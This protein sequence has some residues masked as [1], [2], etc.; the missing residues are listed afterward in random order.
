MQPEKQAPQ[1]FQWDPAPAPTSE[2]VAPLLYGAT[3]Q[4]PQGSVQPMMGM[5]TDMRGEQSTQA[6]MALVLSL[7]SIVGGILFFPAFLLAPVSLSLANKSLNVTKMYPGHSEHGMA[8]AAQ[9]ISAIATTM[10]LIGVIL[11]GLFIALLLFFG[12]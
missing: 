9:I 10:L 2:T 8:R 1:G 3:Q 5:G 12:F 4:I 6:I 11:F 7:I